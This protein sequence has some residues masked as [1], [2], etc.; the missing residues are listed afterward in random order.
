MSDKESPREGQDNGI[1]PFDQELTE[2]RVYEHPLLPRRTI[3]VGFSWPAFLVG[4]ALLLYRRL[5]FP[6]VGLVFAIGFAHYVVEVPLVSDNCFKI[7]GQWYPLNSYSDINCHLRSEAIDFILL[8]IA[9]LWAG[10]YANRL[11]E[12]DLKKRGYVMATSVLANSL[13]DAS[14]RLVRMSNSASTDQG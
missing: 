1:T 14:A 13:D 12:S 2:F 7:N 3:K 8:L 9:N 5:W 6:A 11:W 4:P 10:I